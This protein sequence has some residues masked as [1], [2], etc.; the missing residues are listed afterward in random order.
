MKAVT[1]QGIKN[2]VVK[3]VPDPK[4]EKSDDMI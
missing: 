3:D 1:Y 2:V 4:I